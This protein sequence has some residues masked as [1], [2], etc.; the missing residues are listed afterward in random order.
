MKTPSI[1]SELRGQRFQRVPIW[2]MRQAGRY[3]PEYRVLRERRPTF[4]EFCLTPEL[5]VE[6]TLQP[7]R[8]FPLDAAIIFSDI[9]IVPYG[10]G[11]RVSF[12]E[13][14]GPRL[15]PVARVED[16]ARLSPQRL[17]AAVAPV[18]VAIAEVRRVMP[19]GAALLGFA[20]GPWT[21]ACYMVEGGTSSDFATVKSWA[22]REPEQFQQLIELLIEATA[23]Y[24]ARQV[25]AGA[26]VLQIFDSWAGILPADL[27]GR[28]CLRPTLEIIRHVKSLHPHV[29]FIVFPRGSGASY[30]EY[31]G[32]GA[33]L[34]DGL[35]LDSGVPTAWA[36]AHLQ[37]HCVVQGNL[38]PLLLVIGGAPMR[39]A[40]ERILQDLSGGPF[41]FNVGHGILPQTPP[42]HVDELCAL[43]AAWKRD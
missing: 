31:A 21:V 7:L 34:I 32:A 5:A 27:V 39:E 42:E 10:L 25:T 33:Q 1:V 14:L 15:E 30:L 2:L 28:W 22:F 13:G 16:L 38:D 26:D 40:T 4:M 11:Q 24:L 20:G 35:S 37:R 23:S 41:I 36:S 12:E 17:S 8:R 19:E 18:E 6:A 29:P 43:V 9:L 3:L